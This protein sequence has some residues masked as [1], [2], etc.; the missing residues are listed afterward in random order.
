MLNINVNHAFV[1]G[2]PLSKVFINIQD[3]LDNLEKVLI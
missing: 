2:Y 1:D 3:M